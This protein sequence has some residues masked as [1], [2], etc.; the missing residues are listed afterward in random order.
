MC[1][2]KITQRCQKLYSPCVSYELPIPEFSTLNPTSCISLEDTT[3]DLYLLIEDLLELEGVPGPTGSASTV[4]GPAGPIGPVGPAGPTGSASTVPGPAGPIGPVGPTGPTG[5]SSTVPGPVGPVGPASTVPGPAGPTGSA[6]TVPGPAGP[7]G[8]V[9]PTGPTGSASTV[10]GPVGPVGPASTVPGP[11]GPAGENAANNLQKIISGNYSIVAS[12]NNHTI[13][14]NNVSSPVT[15]SI[16]NG[17]P[18]NFSVGFIQQGTGD[19]NFIKVTSGYIYSPENLL[20]IKGQ[21]YNAYIEQ[22][23]ITNNYHLMGNLKL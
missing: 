20:K 1:N 3:K 12:D 16:P 15:I 5:S 4:P 10:P 18:L 9:G 21:Y 8:P 23:G 11:T 13:L 2:D 6:S 17:L 7:I 14:I 19:V 22:I